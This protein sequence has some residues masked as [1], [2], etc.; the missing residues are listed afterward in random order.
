MSRSEKM[1]AANRSTGQKNYVHA[2]LQAEEVQARDTSS[3][4]SGTS[5][6]D[7]ANARFKATD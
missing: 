1:I 7:I 4:K 6:A 3:E 5:T 2:R